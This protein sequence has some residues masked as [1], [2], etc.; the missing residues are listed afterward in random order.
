MKTTGN[1]G[2]LLS[3]GKM[4]RG[5]VRKL[6]YRVIATASVLNPVRRGQVLRKGTAETVRPHSIEGGVTHFLIQVMPAEVGGNRMNVSQGVLD[7]H[8]V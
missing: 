5:T 2:S 6:I 3:I 7:T 4:V 1:P 8:Y